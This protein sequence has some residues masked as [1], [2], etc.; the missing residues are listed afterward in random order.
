[1]N[2]IVLLFDSLNRRMLPPYNPDT[3]AIAPNFARLAQHAATF[4]NSYVCS[5]PCMPA[6]RDM[7]T[8]RPNFL[9]RSWGPLEPFDDSVPEILSQNGVYTHLITDHYHY[10]EDGGATYHNRFDSWEFYRGQEG[11][12]H[13]G[14]VNDPVIPKHING[15]GRRQDWVNRQHLHTEADYPQTQTFDAGLRFLEA[16]A[17]TDKP[18]MLQLEC[19]D[20]HEPFVSPD[21]FL[22]QYPSDYDGPLFDWP[23]YSEV[24][25]TSQQVAEARRKYLALL[26]QCDHSL[27][28]VLDHMDQHHR[29]DDTLLIVMTD[30][31]YFLGERNLWAKNWMPLYNEVAHTP[32]FIHDPR[33]PHADGTRRSALTQPALDTAPTL[34]KFFDLQPTA[35]MTAHDLGPTLSDDS[36][37]HTDCL[38]GYHNNRVN[39]TDGRYVYLRKPLLQNS[40]HEYLLMP[41]RMRGFKNTA[42]IELVPPFSFTKNMPVLRDQLPHEPSPLDQDPDHLL[43]DLESDPGQQHPLDNPE[44]EARL[45]TRMAQL[46][47]DLD[48]PPEQY[49]RMGLTLP[50]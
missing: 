43:F 32:L 30:H 19:F 26:T 9:H 12:P 45:C 5:M 50:A 10:F 25:E 15:K 36:P 7:H 39:Y 34:L 41:T 35:D 49:A 24:T 2:A 11:D 48:A 16:N 29:W 33:A 31:G 8:G 44:L 23:P 47:H 6:R 20:P 28:R 3:E 27:G 37:A 22:D 42:G 4:D 40:C 21:T 38:F 17:H 13:I 1:M 18:W 14:Q 46:M